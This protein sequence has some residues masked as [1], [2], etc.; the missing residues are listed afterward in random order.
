MN[1]IEVL[2]STLI[3]TITLLTT[4]TLT[5]SATLN[6]VNA[7]SKN[8]VQLKLLLATEALL[9][10]ADNGLAIYSDNTVKHH[11][12]SPAKLAELEK[13]S[14]EEL[15]KKL[16]IRKAW[17]HPKSLKTCVRRMG[18]MNEKPYLLI[19]CGE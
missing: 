10:S 11:Q 14:P 5:L 12:I 18:V 9:T 17:L 2:I 16:G 13:L 6:S 19:L 3:I 7:Y 15:G 8:L 1:S 4:L